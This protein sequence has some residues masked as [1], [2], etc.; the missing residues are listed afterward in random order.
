MVVGWV[1]TGAILLAA[2]GV[3]EFFD[4]ASGTAAHIRGGRPNGYPSALKG[5]RYEAA[6][7]AIYD[8]RGVSAKCSQIWTILR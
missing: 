7:G 3:G 4:S 8:D 5:T 6:D 2:D 1:K